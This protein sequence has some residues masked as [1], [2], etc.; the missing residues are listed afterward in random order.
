LRNVG[1]VLVNYN[2]NSNIAFQL[3]YVRD[4]AC[5]SKAVCLAH[6]CKIYLML[7]FP[8]LI[9]ILK[10][11]LYKERVGKHRVKYFVTDGSTNC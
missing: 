3:M 7:G 2:N 11:S 8:L 10:N 6:L 4:K 1:I 5:L 9:K